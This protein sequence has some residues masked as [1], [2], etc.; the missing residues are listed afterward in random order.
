MVAIQKNDN[1]LNFFTLRLLDWY[2]REK[3]DLPWRE[4]PDPYKVWL[5]EIILQQTR[6]AQGLPYYE[7]FIGRFPNIQA[8]AAAD[9]DEILRLWQGLG[10]YSRARNLH[11]CAKQIV[12]EYDGQ[13]PSESQEL[14]KLKGI[15]RYTAAAIA[16]ICFN[17]AVPVIDGNVYRV[18][19]RVFDIPTDISGNKAYEEFHQRSA[20][21]MDNSRPGDYNQAIMEFGALQCTPKNPDCSQCPLQSGCKAYANQIIAERPVKLSRIKKTV[22]Y[23]NYCLFNYASYCLIRQRE[24]GDIWQGLHEFYNIEGDFDST[25]IEHQLADKIGQVEHKQLNQIAKS[26]PIKHVLTHQILHIRFLIYEVESIDSLK[27]ISTALNLKMIK[28][29][30][31][32]SLGKP[33]IIEKFLKNQSVSLF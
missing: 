5:S 11:F 32:E 17:E 16:S 31:L 8:L 26:G 27:E 33:I 12:N 23:F 13:F 19:S 20:S 30:K 7:R 24:A 22:R 15:G 28:K 25:E 10:Y 6:V 4:K 3:R 2:D 9:Q 1:S 18:L 21:L 14:V 29:D